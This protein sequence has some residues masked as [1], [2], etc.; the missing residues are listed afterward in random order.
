MTLLASP[1]SQGEKAYQGVRVAILGA[2]GFIGRWV[3][4]AM[5]NQGAQVNLIVRDAATADPILSRY[6]V[7]GALFEIDLLKPG[8]VLTLYRKIRPVVTFNLAGYGVDRSERDE[9]MAYRINAHLVG[10]VCEAVASVRDM[11]W[12][13]QDLVHAGSALEYGTLSGDLDENSIPQPTT[14]YGQSKLAGTYALAD[15]CKATAIKGLTARLFTVYGPGENTGRLLPALIESAAAGATLPLTAGTQRRDFTFIEDVA[16]GLVRLGLAKADPGAVVNLATGKLTEVQEF[17]KIAA[18]ILQI[19]DDRLRFG[20]L[21]TRPEE[22]EHSQVTVQRL[23]R[24]TGWVP[25]TTVAEGIRKTVEFE[26][27][28]R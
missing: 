15:A 23:R 13:G 27:L 24:L 10:Q 11:Q 1:D 7:R 4:R 2:A 21:P 3:A 5:C 9:Q 18:G 14:L 12:E 25:G 28:L 20:S 16:E 19:P 22:M 26:R 17:V 6:G 8:A